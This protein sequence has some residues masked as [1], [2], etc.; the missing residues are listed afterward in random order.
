MDNAASNHDSD[1][2]RSPGPAVGESFKEP[3]RSCHFHMLLSLL[4]PLAD[5]SL[6]V[7]DLLDPVSLRWL[8]R[9]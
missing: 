4:P 8:V 2:R 9:R 3:A 7:V 6:L 1:L 5:I